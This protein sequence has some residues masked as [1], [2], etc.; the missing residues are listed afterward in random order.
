MA[1]KDTV[2]KL[3]LFLVFILLFL[4]HWLDR[5]ICFYLLYLF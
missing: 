4:P 3:L 1:A 2:I 5:F